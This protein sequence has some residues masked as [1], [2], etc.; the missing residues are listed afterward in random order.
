MTRSD[1]DRGAACEKCENEQTETLNCRCCSPHWKWISLELLWFLWGLQLTLKQ[2]QFNVTMKADTFSLPTTPS[3]HSFAFCVCMSNNYGIFAKR[4]KSLTIFVFSLFHFESFL[5]L[6]SILSSSSLLH[7]SPQGKLV[8]NNIVIVI[9]KD[10]L[11]YSIS[12]ISHIS[13]TEATCWRK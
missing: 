7:L 13:H 5:W 1:D 6:K 2:H 12:L 11:M 8:K 9:I 3:W 4:K 10:S